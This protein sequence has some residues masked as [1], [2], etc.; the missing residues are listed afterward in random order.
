M[1]HYSLKKINIL[2]FIIDLS[3]NLVDLSENLFD[4]LKMIKS[5]PLCVAEPV[6]TRRHLYN[7]L[8]SLTRKSNP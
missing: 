6:L 1:T 5:T 8:V 7:L 2:D 3:E 4:D